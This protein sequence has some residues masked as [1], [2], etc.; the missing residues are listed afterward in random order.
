MP[1]M[2]TTRWPGRSASWGLPTG[3]SYLLGTYILLIAPVLLT[4]GFFLLCA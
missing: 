1:Q 3:P 2:V 4:V